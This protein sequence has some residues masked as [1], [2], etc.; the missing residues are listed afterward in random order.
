M[1]SRGAW[2]AMAACA[3][4]LL[5]MPAGAAAKNLGTLDA[6]A[7]SIGHVI[8]DGAG[9]AYI[10]WLRKSPS[11]GVADTIEFCKI[12]RGSTCPS[13][14]TLTVPA[15]GAN[16]EGPAGVSPVFGPA[17]Q[18]YLVVPRYVENDVLLYVSENGGASFNA[19]VVIENSYSNKSNPSE[20]FLEGNEF[21]I[22][23][24]NAGLGFSAVNTAGEGLGHFVLNEPGPGGVASASM[25][26]DS[27]GNPVVA[28]YNLTSPPYPIDFVHYNGSGSKTTEADWSQ[29]A[30][31][32]S[33]YLP[34]LAG[35]ASGLFLLS[36]DYPSATAPYATVVDVRKYT[37][38]SFGPPVK[39]FEDPESELYNGGDIAQSPGGHL[40]VVWPK[41]SGSAPTMRLLVST[42]GGTSFSA[43]TAVATLGSAYSDQ[44]NAQATIND[45]GGGW[46][47]YNDAGGLELADLTPLNGSGGSSKSGTSTSNKVGNDVVTLAGPKG[48]VKPGAT[49]TGRLSVRSSKRKHKVVLKIYQVKFGVDGSIFKTL[50][51]EKVRRTGKV[52]PHPYVAT[53]KG[54]Y[55]AGSTHILSAQAFI[56][57]RHGKH[58]SRTLKVK[59]LVCS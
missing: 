51:R 34:Q 25:G 21:L 37:G 50:V 4:M 7:D 5:C 42:N 57:E 13:P 19:P 23:G 52:D 46:L 45:D 47:V 28:Y 54:T 48:C 12:P 3:A 29:P 44:V 30:Q 49:V 58:A 38:S 24:Y 56:S 35:G 33:G 32:A 27:A 6:Q 31:V 20:V 18:V 17:G 11:T 39:L 26:L 15:P 40:A 43:P 2:G 9:T 59:F 10:A 14:V 22:S 41:F 16:T 1:T 8:E 53:V 55:A 36:E